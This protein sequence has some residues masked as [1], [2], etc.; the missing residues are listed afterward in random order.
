ME[1]QT[2]NPKVMGLSLSI[3]CFAISVHA[4]VLRDPLVQYS[5]GLNPAQ[6]YM[7]ILMPSL[8]IPEQMELAVLEGAG[9]Y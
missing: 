7:A 5:Q 2:C 8:T 1:S 4:K 6:I 3:I 9:Q